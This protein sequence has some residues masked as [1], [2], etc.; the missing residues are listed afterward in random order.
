MYP[1]WEETLGCEQIINESTEGALRRAHPGTPGKNS[2][3]KKWMLY[4]NLA[5][6]AM[7]GLG[8]T[9]IL[10]AGISLEEFSLTLI[11]AP[12]AMLFGV[13]KDFTENVGQV[14]IGGTFTFA[15]VTTIFLATVTSFLAWAQ[16][17]ALSKD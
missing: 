14:V 3:V 17:K 7:L 10:S 13:G 4:G 11:L 1:A 6:F 2:V 8:T 16:Q 5:G 9:L 15:G 12:I